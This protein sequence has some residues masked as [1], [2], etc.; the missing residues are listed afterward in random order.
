MSI[1]LYSAVFQHFFNCTSLKVSVFTKPLGDRWCELYQ[2]ESVLVL[3]FSW[4]SLPSILTQN[5]KSE[6]LSSNILGQGCP[7]LAHVCVTLILISRH[8]LKGKML[9]I[10]TWIVIYTFT[11]LQ[12]FELECVRPRHLSCS[13]YCAVVFVILHSTALT[14]CKFP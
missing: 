6:A 12:R 14:T 13:H 10:Y 8:F 4:D 7:S 11:D 3:F 2:T 9:H 1:I 5:Q